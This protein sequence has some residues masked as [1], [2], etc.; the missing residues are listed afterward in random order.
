MTTAMMSPAVQASPDISLTPLTMRQ[1]QVLHYLRD[2]IHQQGYAPT[3]QEIASALQIQSTSSV[4]NHI[5]ALEAAGLLQRLSRRHR[6]IRLPSVQSSSPWPVTGDIVINEPL[7]RIQP[8]IVFDFKTWL[9]H[10][11]CFAV[12]VKGPAMC[13]HHMIDG[14]LLLCE[15][16]CMLE[17]KHVVLA[18]INQTQPD[19]KYWHRETHTHV[20]LSSLGSAA[21]ILS[22]S[23][24]FVVLHGRYLG[25]VRPLS[26]QVLSVS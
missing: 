17:S 3:M 15:P 25:M 24:T 6:N 1:H 13:H 9:Q 2:F 20:Y 7:Q 4:Y 11:K 23:K 22:Y 16:V 19:L 18:T 12:R 8:T 26:G 21:D 5:R 14:D 10:P